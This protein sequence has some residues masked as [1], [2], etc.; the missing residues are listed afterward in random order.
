MFAQTLQRVLIQ[1][2]HDGVAGDGRGLVAV[3]I[4]MRRL[5]A[6]DIQTGIRG[7]LASGCRCQYRQVQIVKAGRPASSQAGLIKILG[8]ILPVLVLLA[9]KMPAPQEILGY[10]FNWKSLSN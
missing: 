2:L 5:A 9:G 7:F 3:D 8:H 4:Q 10:F 6:R 1:A